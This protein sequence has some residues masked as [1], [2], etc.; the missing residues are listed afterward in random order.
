MST[1]TPLQKKDVPVFLLSVD[2]LMLKFP[3]QLFLFR[4]PKRFI[5]IFTCSPNCNT[6]DNVDF[7]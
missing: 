6:E 3:N 7:S 1:P 2:V 5:T 4:C